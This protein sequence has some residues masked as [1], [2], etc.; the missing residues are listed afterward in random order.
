M[1]EGPAQVE[2]FHEFLI[3]AETVGAIGNIGANLLLGDLPKLQADLVSRAIATEVQRRVEAALGPLAARL[4]QLSVPRAGATFPE[5]HGRWWI[6]TS[7]PEGEKLTAH[8]FLDHARP[9]HCG[10]STL[11]GRTWVKLTSE[12]LAAVERRG[13]ICPRCLE[14]ERA[15]H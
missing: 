15:D 10:A 5:S 3:E 2:A 11:D 14:S 6:P 1:P 9:S 8:F 4:E 7:A 12:N 13:A